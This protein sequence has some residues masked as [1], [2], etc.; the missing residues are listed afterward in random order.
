MWITMRI[1]KGS[2]IHVAATEETRA[3]I[4]G[5]F[6]EEGHLEGSFD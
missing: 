6:L 3:K 4:I 2:R 5:E 1:L